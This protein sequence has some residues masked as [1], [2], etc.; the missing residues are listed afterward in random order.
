MLRIK[1]KKF[2]F[3]IVDPPRNGLYKK[4]IDLIS[5]ITNK[6]VIYVSCDPSTLAR[7][8]SIFLKKNFNLMSVQPFDMF[9]NTYH[10]ENVVI[11]EKKNIERGGEK[12]YLSGRIVS[13]ELS[14]TME[15]N[16]RAM[17]LQSKGEKVIRLTAGGNQILGHQIQS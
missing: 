15:L 4:E 12:L 10:I 3:V 17:E 8:L 2:D 6:A 5:N 7:D 13:L 1:L 16:S 14:K 9:P 11:L